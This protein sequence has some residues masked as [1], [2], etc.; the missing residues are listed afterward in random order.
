MALR[1]EEEARL[2]K[3]HIVVFVVRVAE[4]VAEAEVHPSNDQTSTSRP[5]SHMIVGL[6]TLSREVVSRLSR[7]NGTM[8]QPSIKM[9]YA[10]RDRWPL[11]L[12]RASQPACQIY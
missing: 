4:V 5:I 7:E 1:A 11:L 8:L 12:F 9:P 2:D 10:S 6:D 3:T